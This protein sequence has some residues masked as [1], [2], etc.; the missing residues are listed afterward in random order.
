MK[1]EGNKEEAKRGIEGKVNKRKEECEWAG[2]FTLL[3]PSNR[4]FWVLFVD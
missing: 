3:F 2:R 4:R 1:A